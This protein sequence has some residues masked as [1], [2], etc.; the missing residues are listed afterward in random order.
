MV[1]WG[2]EPPSS[3]G[4]RP[5][6]CIPAGEKVPNNV[7]GGKLG[8]GGMGRNALQPVPSVQARHG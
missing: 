3:Y 4:I 5:F 7:P 1:G 8:G 6:E 2:G